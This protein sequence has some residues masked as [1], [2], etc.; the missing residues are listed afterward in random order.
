MSDNRPEMTDNGLA[1]NGCHPRPPCSAMTA[2]KAEVSHIL[3]TAINGTD[4][5][6]RQ[7]EGFIRW[8]LVERRIHEAI[9]RNWPNSVHHMTTLGGT[10]S[11]ETK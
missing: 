6:L 1:A 7:D 3:I 11:E 5:G 10:M 2:C 9:A 8:G 4:K